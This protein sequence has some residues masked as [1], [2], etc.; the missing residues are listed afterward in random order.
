MFQ[1]IPQG[2]IKG[3]AFYFGV[4]FVRYSQILI[5]ISS[6]Y[7]VEEHLVIHMSNGVHVK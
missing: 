2:M 6:A 3:L 1:D 5:R 7:P 4:C